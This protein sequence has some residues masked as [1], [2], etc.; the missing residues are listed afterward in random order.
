[1]VSGELY[2][3]HTYTNT[4]THTHTHTCT[5]ALGMAGAAVGVL[6]GF[7]NTVIV[8]VS[9]VICGQLCWEVDRQKRSLNRSESATHA[10]NDVL[11]LCTLQER[12]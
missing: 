3:T 1:M 5:H 2:H 11:N 9:M 8:M 12:R 6:V 7:V 4:N 10:R